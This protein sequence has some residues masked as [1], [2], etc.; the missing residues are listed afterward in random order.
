MF[1][2]LSGMLVAF[3]GVLGRVVGAG[4]ALR[5]VGGVWK[6]ISERFGGVG[7]TLRECWVRLGGGVGNG[8]LSSHVRMYGYG[9]EMREDRSVFLRRVLEESS[10]LPAKQ[11]SLVLTC[12]LSQFKPIHNWF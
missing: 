8:S 5:G 4:G 3:V 10:I 12:I 6:V 11:C 2:A 9:E 1:S 7:S